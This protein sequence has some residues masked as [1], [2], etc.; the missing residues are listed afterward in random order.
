MSINLDD[1][2]HTLLLAIQFIEDGN[3]L[4]EE[5]VQRVRATEAIPSKTFLAMLGTAILA[6]ATDPR[7]DPLTLKVTAPPAPGFLSY[8]AR[9]VATGA[10]AP[11]SIEYA[12]DI[13]TRGREPLNNQPFFHNV[14]VHRSM[15]V[16]SRVRPHLD[17]FVTTLERL[18][19]LPEDELVAALAAFV[20]L[21]R[22]AA[23]RPPGRIA[24][25]TTGWTPA[26]MIAATADFVTTYPEEGRRG[27]ALVA[28]A[29]DLVFDS[30]RVGHIN[31]PSRSVPGDVH[32][33]SEA[34][35]VAC[36]VEVKQ[37]PVAEHEILGWVATVANTRLKKAFFVALALSQPELD[38]QLGQTALGLH[39]V[40]L[41]V[42]PGAAALMHEAMAYSR[43]DTEH[44]MAEFPERML[45]RLAEVGVAE[46]TLRDWQE[47]FG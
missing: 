39:G 44:F 7:I 11:L 19:E 40:A 8:S 15:T 27:Q 5:W 9:G 18:R 16:H 42:I 31:D 12:V 24:I 20:A 13:G 14:T 43:L 29:F 37:R 23:R 41:R 30:V 1:C 34:G 32:I 10:L 36:C 28:A 45:Q 35:G 33:G 3:P 4:P 6:R 46:E 2:R 25:S 26:E 21:R 17:A 47:L 22:R 38:V